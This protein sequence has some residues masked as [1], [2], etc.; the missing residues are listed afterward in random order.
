MNNE[1]TPKNILLPSFGGSDGGA[2][3]RGSI[4]T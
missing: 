4:L 3:I 2:V 1:K